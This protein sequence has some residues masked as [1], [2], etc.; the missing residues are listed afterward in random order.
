MGLNFNERFCSP[1][2]NTELSDRLSPVHRLAAASFIKLLCIFMTHWWMNNQQWALH[3][4]CGTANLCCCTSPKKFLRW[5]WLLRRCSQTLRKLRYTD[6]AERVSTCVPTGGNRISERRSGV[7]LELTSGSAGL[8]SPSCRASRTHS[9][10]RR[11]SCG[12][13]CRR[14]F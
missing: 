11:R 1:T 4:K 14:S 13:S 2:V 5:R 12:C 10:R 3:C 7:G 9:R 8:R 6:V